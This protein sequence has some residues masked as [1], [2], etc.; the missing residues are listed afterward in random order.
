MDTIK[1]RWKRSQVL[2]LQETL[3]VF[4]EIVG[5]STFLNGIIQKKRSS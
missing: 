5:V 3:I 2:V 1:R 4:V